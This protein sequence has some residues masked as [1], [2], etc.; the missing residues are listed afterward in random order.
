MY[1][2]QRRKSGATTPSKVPGPAAPKRAQNVAS[3]LH[4]FAAIS[5]VQRMLAGHA[6]ADDAAPLSNW[7]RK[8]RREL[9][10]A[11]ADGD[12]L[13]RV[14]AADDRANR[15]R[16]LLSNHIEVVARLMALSGDRIFQ[17][18]Y[19]IAENFW[20]KRQQPGETVRGHGDLDVRE[21]VVSGRPGWGFRGAAGAGKAWR[22]VTAWHTMSAFVNYIVR[23]GYRDTLIDFVQQQLTAHH[24]DNDDGDRK[25]VLDEFAKAGDDSGGG[26]EAI[27]RALFVMNSNKRNLWAGASSQNTSI[28]ST[29]A[30]LMR[31]MNA[32][33]TR[34]RGVTGTA[35]EVDAKRRNAVQERITHREGGGDSGPARTA[36]E[37]EVDILRRVLTGEL[38]P[39]E[40][41][42]T[43]REYILPSFEIDTN[44]NSAATARRF[45][46]G[47]PQI[48]AAGKRMYQT[49]HDAPRLERGQVRELLEGTIG[50]FLSYKIPAPTPAQAAVRHVA[51]AVRESAP[52]RAVTSAP[53]AGHAAV[54]GAGIGANLGSRVGATVGT[55]VGAVAGGVAGFMSTG[56][57]A[58]AGMAAGGA[59]VGAAAGRAVGWFAGRV[60]GAIGG[61]AA[62]TGAYLLRN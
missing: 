32:L 60:A 45:F 16:E 20:I 7:L 6:A 30:G 29:S 14:E 50:P 13:D 4:R 1:E 53:S 25:K 8:L 2:H 55:V 56:G 35:D 47:D 12:V 21:G 54:R 3:Q 52:A 36:R 49:L 24:L 59:A 19:K 9:E 44:F 17:R 38:D 43:V 15:E 39:L 27:K 18:A 46:E 26:D 40:A 37:V 11:G 61:A 58:S 34:M 42:K 41:P 10:D 28:N 33:E 23:S 31:G 51:T 62:A 48:I 22:H 57:L 5:P